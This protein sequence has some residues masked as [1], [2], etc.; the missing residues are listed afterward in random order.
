MAQRYFFHGIFLNTDPADGPGAG[1]G[2]AD[3]VT[4]AVGANGA[5]AMGT[6]GGAGGRGARTMAGGGTSVAAAGGVEPAASATRRRNS[7][8]RAKWDSFQSV[9]EG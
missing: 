3:G 6:E 2:A 5:A 9:M 8:A 7:R 1:C 4:G